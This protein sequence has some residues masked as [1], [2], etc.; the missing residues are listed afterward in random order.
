MTERELYK[1]R[2]SMRTMERLLS[3]N[4][5]AD[6]DCCGIKLNE[7]H[8]LMEL[9]GK[10]LVQISDL[11]EILGMDKSLL[12]RTIDTMVRNGYILRMENPEDRRQK[13][14]TLSHKGLEM[15][16]KINSLMNAKYAEIL[17]DLDD[18]TTVKAI[19]SMEFLN[20]L[21]SSLDRSSICCR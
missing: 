6:V 12:S 5:K 14:L 17:K 10:S 9:D 18:E 16:R 11:S 1:F 15:N 2:Q 4:I 8:I 21:F 13:N 7:C 20:S 3:S 19:E